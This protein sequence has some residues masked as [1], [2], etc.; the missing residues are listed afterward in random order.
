MSI[1]NFV[2]NKD[3]KINF[4]SDLAFLNKIK[5]KLNLLESYLCVVN[6]TN[7]SNDYKENILNYSKGLSKVYF[8]N[9]RNLN[10]SYLPSAILN[11]LVNIISII[12]KDYEI[13]YI[14]LQ[15]ND[16]TNEVAPFVAAYF[17]YGIA[18]NLIDIELVSAN[19]LFKS[20]SYGS[21]SISSFTIKNNKILLTFKP[22]YFEFSNSINSN[23][24]VD[25]QE[26]D[27]NYEEAF[28]KVRVYGI[29]K[30]EKI[31]PKLEDAKVIVSGGRGLG[32]K[33]G[34]ELLREL[35]NLLGGTVGASRAAV[36]SNWI[37]PNF[38]IGQTG[39]T[40]SPEL[41]IA[42]GISG[43]TQHIAGMNKS[44]VIV[45]IN[46]D[47]DAPIFK[48]SHIGIVEDYKV[49]LPAI[50]QEIKKFKI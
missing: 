20:F 50:I 13:N 18:T 38:Q 35:A 21:K 10:D 6:L 32:S 45:A 7:I 15:A 14:S 26:L 19:L 37:E 1:I 9:I 31:G 12:L 49:I 17:N 47:K 16:I 34:F 42:V 25:F 24:S 27:I 36:D 29:S 5:E 44:K 4:L 39:K 41:Y 8:F 33:E 30:A 43:A 2:L 11:T 23:V 48:H 46:N 22:N 28:N 3:N 40:V